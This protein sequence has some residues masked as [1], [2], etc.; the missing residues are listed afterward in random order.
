MVYAEGTAADNPT[1]GAVRDLPAAFD[2][3]SFPSGWIEQAQQAVV[4]ADAER[5]L[6]LAAAVA[7][8][9]PALATAL[10]AYIHDF[11]YA[12][13]LSVIGRIQKG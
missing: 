6:Q 12:S 5:L 7:D 13:I 4:M 3:T 8:D 11:D 10:I 2:L 9:Q 1:A